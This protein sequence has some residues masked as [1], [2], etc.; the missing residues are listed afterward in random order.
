MEKLENPNSIIGKSQ[1]IEKPYF[2]ISTTPDLDTIRPKEILKKALFVMQEKWKSKLANYDYISE[3]L[4]S[5][6]QDM[7][8]QRINDEFAI[9]V[10]QTHSKIALENHDI[11][12]F[13]QCQIQLLDLYQD[14]KLTNN[15][16]RDEFLG[17]ELLYKSLH[18]FHIELANLLKQ[19]TSKERKSKNILYSMAVYRSLADA[20]YIQFFKLYKESPNLSA[21]LLDVFI[22]RIRVFA[23]QTIAST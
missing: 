1:N 10:Y 23:L 3:Q 2:R 14:N 4:R 17:Y 5:I 18:N 21:K 19:L 20:N 15:I 6:R 16:K 7:V 9:E 11:T 22:D 8:L 13:H 12:Q